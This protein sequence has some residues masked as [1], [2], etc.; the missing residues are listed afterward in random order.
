VGGLLGDGRVS[1][2]VSA[3][4]DRGW[5]TPVF[6]VLEPLLR[7]LETEDFEAVATCLAQLEA[8]DRHNPWIAL[9]TARLHEA[10]GFFET[11]ADLYRQLL[12]QATGQKLL[13]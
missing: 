4:G 2:G 3:G 6:A 10:R 12:Q 8:S 7:A 5:E 9:G 13:S 1:V 11:A